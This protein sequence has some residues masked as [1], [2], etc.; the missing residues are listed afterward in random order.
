[1][2][3]NDR[4]PAES[5]Q[6]MADKLAPP[7]IYDPVLEV[8]KRDVDRTLLRENLKLTPDERVRKFVRF[9]KEQAAVRGVACNAAQG[10]GTT[11]G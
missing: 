5:G 8:Y 6:A 7:D 1:M 10:S 11:Q 3:S 4:Q 2:G 9:L